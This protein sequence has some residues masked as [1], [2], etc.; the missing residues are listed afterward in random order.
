MYFI[1]NNVFSYIIQAIST[2]KSSSF[3]FSANEA[4]NSHRKF[5]MLNWNG[6]M[7]QEGRRL[8]CGIPQAAYEVEAWC[9]ASPDL[10]LVAI[11]FH[12][13]LGGKCH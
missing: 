1:A 3:K 11:F 12:W 8:A 10:K 6:L 13:S 5:E 9:K 2:I 4:R 7:N